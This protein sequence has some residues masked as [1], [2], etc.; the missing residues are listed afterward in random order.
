VAREKGG[1]ADAGRKVNLTRRIEMQTSLMTADI[2]VS[3][4]DSNTSITRQPAVLQL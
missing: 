2:E 1:Q 3:V 4:D